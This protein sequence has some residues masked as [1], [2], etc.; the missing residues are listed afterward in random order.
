M[1]RLTLVLTVSAAMMLA[2]A[3]ALYAK[4]GG[5]NGASGNAG[6][7]HAP[8]ATGNPHAPGTTGNPHQS[9]PPGNPG[10]PTGND[11]SAAS[12]AVVPLSGSAA[13]SASV[14][15]AP[16]RAATTPPGQAKSKAKAGKTTICHRT[17]SA[18]NPFVLITVSD[19]ALPAHAKHGDLLPGPS[20]TCADATQ[21]ISAPS[22]S[23]GSAGGQGVKGVKKSSGSGA[24]SDATS[25]GTPVADTASDPDSGGGLPFTGE[26]VWLLL[27]IGVGACAAGLAIHRAH[28]TTSS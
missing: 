4:P 14:A 2:L 1:R 3:P 17:G 6:N 8:G 16:S 13:G 18:T 22:S 12:P 21:P 23:G 28:R 24:G 10:H 19:H 15:S 5:G 25:L 7:P 27:L 9:G 11:K 26:N 20:G